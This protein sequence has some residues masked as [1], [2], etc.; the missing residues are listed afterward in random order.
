M[1]QAVFT[2]INLD[3]EPHP[4]TGDFTKLSDAN[5]VKRSVRNLVLT[6]R[7]EHPYQPEVGSGVRGLLFENSSEETYVAIK[8]RVQY[9]IERYEPRA[10]L[11]SIEVDGEAAE[12]VDRNEV[13]ITIKF[14]VGSSATPETVQVFLERVR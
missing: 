2:D 1:A 13:A 6:N 11:I 7:Y 14:F 8:E 9:V 10:E 5:A 12:L 4:V 3:F